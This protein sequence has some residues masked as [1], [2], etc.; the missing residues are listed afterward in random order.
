MDKTNHI[1]CWRR[2]EAVIK[3]ADMSTNF[4][5]RQIGLSRPDIFYNIKSG[6][7]NLSHN[8]AKRIVDRFPEISAAWLLTG[9][10]TMLGA[11]SND[12]RIPFYE[13]RVTGNMLLGQ[14]D[15]TPSQYLYVPI[16]EDCDCAFRSYDDAMAADIMP[17]SIVF[18]KKTD[19]NAIIPGGIYV[20]VS[21]NFI[22]L[23]RVYVALQEDGSRELSLNGSN[24]AYDTLKV[25]EDQ[26]KHIFRVVGA[27]RMF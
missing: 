10:G 9:E 23:R 6:K 18:L 1:E 12:C 20:V 4:F 26:V 11:P 16:V 5:S 27:L 3:W 13:G 19:L 15:V 22:L 24:G 17:G 25:A 14:K 7:G 8:L 2:L 21:T